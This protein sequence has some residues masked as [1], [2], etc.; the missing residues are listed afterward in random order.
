MDSGSCSGYCVL[1]FVYRKDKPRAAKQ[2]VRKIFSAA[3][4]IALHPNIGRP[5]R[6]PNTR[7]FI[8]T[9]TPFI[10][11]YRVQKGAL[12]GFTRAAWSNGRAGKVMTKSL[13][14]IILISVFL[15]PLR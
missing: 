4:T 6:T 11:P 10:V 9:G 5:G 2:V 13:F 14:V 3:K 1:T 7:E 12:E 8:V 15:S